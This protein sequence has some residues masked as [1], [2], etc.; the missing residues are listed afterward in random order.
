MQLSDNL[1]FGTYYWRVKT[2][3]GLGDEGYL[4]E[5][6]SFIVEKDNTK[7]QKPIRL[8]RSVFEVLEQEPTY[9]T[10]TIDK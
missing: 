7:P 2:R 6:C 1:N 5:I 8:K 3:D 4:G 10:Q 9:S